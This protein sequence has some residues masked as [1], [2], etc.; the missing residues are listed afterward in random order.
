MYLERSSK[1]MYIYKQDG[2]VLGAIKVKM[3]RSSLKVQVLDVIQ[4]RQGVGKELLKE[5]ARIALAEGAT[6]MYLF[7]TDEGVPFYEAMGG[8]FVNINPKEKLYAWSAEDLR[9]LLQK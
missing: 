2:K 8:E 4:K 9:N 6:R 3:E 5:A 1:G 7:S